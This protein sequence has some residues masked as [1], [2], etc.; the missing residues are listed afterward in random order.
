MRTGGSLLPIR[1]KIVTPPP[2]Q[3]PAPDASTAETTQPIELGTSPGVPAP[4]KE[5]SPSANPDDTLIL[6]PNE[7]FP[8]TK[9]RGPVW[10]V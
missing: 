2:A 10:P 4:A 6:K 5:P 8:R 1:G 9:G 7:E 3:E